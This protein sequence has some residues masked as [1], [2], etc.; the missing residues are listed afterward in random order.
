MDVSVLF[1]ASDR[2]DAYYQLDSWI[3]LL[4]FGVL[5]MSW[6]IF[7]KTGMRKLFT[8]APISLFLH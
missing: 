1:S 6:Y 3:N 2:E 7:V 4:T 8:K 5:S